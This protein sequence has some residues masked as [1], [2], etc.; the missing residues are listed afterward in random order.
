MIYLDYAANTPVDPAVLEVFCQTEKRFGGNAGA[1]HEAGRL[2]EAE[3][4]R[5]TASLADLLRVKPDEIIFTSGASEANNLALKGLARA[6]RHRGKHIISTCLEH[7]SVS[8]PLAAL[9]EQGFTVELVDILPDGRVDLAQ[10]R[11]SLRSDT[12]ILS[13]CQVDSELGAVQPIREIGAILRDYPNCRFHVDAT[14]AMGKIPVC[15][16]GI[17]CL[18]FAPHKFYGLNGSGVLLRREGVLLEPLIHGGGRGAHYRGGT[19]A[20]GLAAAASAAL[21][22]ALAERAPRLALVRALRERLL[23]GLSR[24]ALVR[25]NSP[26]AASPYILNLSVAGVRGDDFQAAL[27]R[28][29]VCVSV[30]SACSVPGTPSR[31]DYAVSGDR[32]NAACSWRISL[33]HL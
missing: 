7:P 1:R 24:C 10:L 8:A 31:A 27:D 28:E 29:G 17:D 18:S 33:S 14:Q 20:L 25:L 6:Y 16:E 12:I 13:V 22:T 26:A 15:F 9:Q 4:E 19:A 5:V 3:L 30:K 2:A 21:A 32:K 23:L 11:E